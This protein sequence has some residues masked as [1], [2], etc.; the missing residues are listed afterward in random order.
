ME[1]PQLPLYPYLAPYSWSLV[2]SFNEFACQQ[3]KAFHGPTSDGHDPTK[4]LW[5]ATYLNPMTYPQTID[6][7]FRCHRMAPFCFFNGNTFVAI[8]RKISEKVTSDPL[9]LNVLR[10]V[11]GHIVAGTDRAGEREKLLNALAKV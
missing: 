2:T 9:K 11:A 1:S 10:T 3:G 5:E 4:A 7:L 8:A 6:F